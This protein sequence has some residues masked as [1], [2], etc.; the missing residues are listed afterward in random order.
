MLDLSPI[1]LIVIVVVILVVLGPDKLPDVARQAGQAWHTLRN[2]Q[3]KIESEVR[4]AVPDL[5]SSSDIVRMARNPV[6]LLNSLADKAT[7][8]DTA[9]VSEVDLDA[10]RAAE[11]TTM[12]DV[13]AEPDDAKLPPASHMPVSRRKFSDAPLSPPDP[14]LN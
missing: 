4:E 3:S 9:A 5:P 11:T 7:Q 1:K 8:D 2:L 10:D 13:L 6:G 12:D 14:T